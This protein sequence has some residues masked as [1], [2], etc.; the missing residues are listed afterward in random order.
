MP[1]KCY[2]TT[3][4]V[5]IQR[6]ST[7][8]SWIIYV[9]MSFNQKENNN[10]KDLLEYWNTYKITTMEFTNS[11]KIIWTPNSQKRH[12]YTQQQQQQQHLLRLLLGKERKGSLEVRVSRKNKLELSL[13]ERSCL[14]RPLLALGSMGRKSLYQVISGSGL[15]LAAQSMVA[16]RVRSTTLSWGPMSMLGKPGGSRSSVRRRGAGESGLGS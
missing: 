3:Q 12:L 9:A 7:N 14:M 2:T 5:Q 16:V 8:V 6:N 10:C 15:P 4:Q 1:N 11:K 13:P